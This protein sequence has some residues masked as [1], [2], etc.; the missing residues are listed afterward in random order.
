MDTALGAS[1]SSRAVPAI[2]IGGLMAGALDIIAAFKIYGWG[3]P[4][5]I[6]GGLLG[7]AAML[8]IHMFLVGL[9][10]AWSVRRYAS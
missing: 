10:I 2:L 7:P 3:V 5:V 1:S 6:A 9:P 4:R 8:L